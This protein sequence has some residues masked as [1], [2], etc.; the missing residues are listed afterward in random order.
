MKPF[1]MPLVR[2]AATLVLALAVTM[3]IL[4]LAGAPPVHTLAVLATGSF[5]SSTAILRTLSAM[6]PLLLCGAGLG[7]TFAVNLWNIGVEGQIILGSIGSLWVL[8]AFDPTGS[9]SPVLYQIGAL[10]AAMVFGA[11]WALFSGLLR[12]QGRVHEI[13][14]GLGLNFVALGLSLWLILDPWKRPGMASMSGTEPLPALL[15]LPAW[16]GRPMS[17]VGLV[18][19]VCAFACVTWLRRRTFFGLTLT[20]VRHNP[21]AAALLGLAPEKRMLAA[22]G[23]CGALAGLAGGLLVAGLYHRLIPSISGMYGYTAILAVLM[24]SGSLPLLP[25]ACLFFAALTVGSIQLPLELGLDSSLSG[26]IQGVL[27]LLV[28]AIRQLRPT[29]AGRPA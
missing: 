12:T 21:R 17:L 26:V 2:A 6:V 25:L 24:V 22:M 15:R 11:A 8:R 18:L 4:F 27:L 1:A 19:A 23:L 5:G 20:A 13:F 10:L 3:G 7:L 9:A 14:S 16:G 29:D 28:F